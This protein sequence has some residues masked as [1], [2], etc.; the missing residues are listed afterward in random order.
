[1]LAKTEQEDVNTVFLN[2]VLIMQSAII[3]INANVTVSSDILGLEM[4]SAVV[5]LWKPV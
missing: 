4:I 2:A 5:R 1:L 3:A